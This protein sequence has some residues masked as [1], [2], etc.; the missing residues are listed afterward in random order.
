[1]TTPS[2]THVWHEVFAQT[3]PSVLRNLLSTDMV[4]TPCVL[5]DGQ[6]LL[7]T[8]LSREISQALIHGFQASPLKEDPRLSDFQGMASFHG[9]WEDRLNLQAVA[10]SLLD[11]RDVQPW[12]TT[13]PTSGERALDL[14]VENNLV[15]VVEAIF[16]RVD[17]QEKQAIR[18][19]A[20]AEGWV[21]KAA[22]KNRFN[23]LCVLLENGCSPT[24]TDPSGRTP[25]FHARN[26]RV[27]ERLLEAGGSLAER[28][29]K[30]TLQEHWAKELRRERYGN[31]GLSALLALG[32]SKP[33]GS[34]GDDPEMVK[35]IAWFESVSRDI[36][37]HQGMQNSASL[38]KAWSEGWQEHMEPVL[39]RRPQL[40]AWSRQQDSG[41]LK[42]KVTLAAALG[43][44][45][46]N[47]PSNSFHYPVHLGLLEAPERLFGAQPTLVRKGVTDWGLF[48]LGALVAKPKLNN[49]ENARVKELASKSLQAIGRIQ[50]YKGT[51]DQWLAC[52]LETAATL[53]R[54]KNVAM[55]RRM[56]SCLEALLASRQAAA[57]TQQSA[58]HGSTRLASLQGQLV[59][60]QTAWSALESGMRMCSG[61]QSIGLLN[62]VNEWGTLT[63]LTT[64]NQMPRQRYL[65]QWTVLA[66]ATL[67]DHAAVVAH[68]KASASSFAAART[69]D[70]E[71]G[72][73]QLVEG[74][75]KHAAEL[76]GFPPLPP[77]FQPRLE[78]ALD[79]LQSW[80]GQALYARWK[81][82]QLDK[83]LNSSPDSLVVSRKPRL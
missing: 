29:G 37:V 40:H 56:G 71:K 69:H 73:R 42:G 38:D 32:S 14:A 41:V 18:A 47:V 39:A 53:Q 76:E 65:E 2:P 25:L 44:I 31:A 15:A 3:P 13:V 28:A 62:R 67:C 30:V 72:I 24:S 66:L 83:A 51:P 16:Q 19:H 11:R 8:L 9:T 7:L 10:I 20:Q 79:H 80:G 57:T 49:L 36:S 55:W 6:D 27:A 75:E 33:S 74:L 70:F 26:L 61:T 64:L 5:E 48:A 54:P 58:A 46:L 21:H 68:D 17:E 4:P 78:E 34:E 22:A 77:S 60:W 59:A 81:S 82:Q 12:S 63:A 45:L 23:L 43:G 50:D 1:M 52:T 35:A